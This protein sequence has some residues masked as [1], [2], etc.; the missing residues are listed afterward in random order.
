M[1][2]GMPPQHLSLQPPGQLNLLP[3]VGGEMS[4]RQRAAMF[5]S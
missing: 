5:C 2:K 1:G 4:T 3:Y